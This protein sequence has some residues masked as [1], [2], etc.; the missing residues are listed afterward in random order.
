MTDGIDDISLRLG[1]GI[2]V[3]SPLRGVSTMSRPTAF[4]TANLVESS[5][6]TGT[7]LVEPGQFLTL[8]SRN[9]D[10]LY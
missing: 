6:R 4:T 10:T 3:L 2:A 5:F 1:V 9:Y 8:E 7:L